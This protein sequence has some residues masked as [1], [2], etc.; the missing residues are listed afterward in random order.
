M[1]KMMKRLGGAM[2]M[3]LLFTACNKDE[4][5][6]STTSDVKYPQLK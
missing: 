5:P 6:A 4:V 2:L 1:N 3:Y